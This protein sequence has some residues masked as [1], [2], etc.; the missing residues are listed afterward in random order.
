LD[1]ACLSHV[2][3]GLPVKRA[4]SGFVLTAKGLRMAEV[5][6]FELVRKAATRIVEAV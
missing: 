1:D 5:G 2:W 3:R 6:K 4:G